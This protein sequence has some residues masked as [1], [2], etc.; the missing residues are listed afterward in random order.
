MHRAPLVHA[1]TPLAMLL[2]CALWRLV[3]IIA[4]ARLLSVLRLRSASAPG[5]HAAFVLGRAHVR[6]ALVCQRCP[7]RQAG[8]DGRSRAARRLIAIGRNRPAA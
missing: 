6:H 4:L 1:A 7:P 8:D 3:P 2:S 5:A